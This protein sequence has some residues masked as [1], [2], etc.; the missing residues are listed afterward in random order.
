MSQSIAELHTA[1]QQQ[2][3]QQQQQP[4][5][6][7]CQTARQPV[8]RARQTLFPEQVTNAYKERKGHAPCTTPR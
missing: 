2:Q 5:Q 6:R 8:Q 1:Q 7:A 3:Q 4:E